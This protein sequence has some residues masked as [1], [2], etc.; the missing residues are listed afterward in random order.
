[1]STN[2]SEPVKK[3]SLPAKKPS[4]IEMAREEDPFLGKYIE[5]QCPS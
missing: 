1:M 2:K 4:L 5:A 3:K